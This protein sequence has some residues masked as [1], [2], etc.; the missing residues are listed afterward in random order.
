M[1]SAVT[2]GLSFCLFAYLLIGILAYDYVGE[3]I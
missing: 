3:K 2:V 1:I